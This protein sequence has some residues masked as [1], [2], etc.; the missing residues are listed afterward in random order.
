ML[1]EFLDL[2]SGLERQGACNETELPKWAAWKAWSACDGR[3]ADGDN[4]PKDR[5]H[6]HQSLRA[7][8]TLKILSH[9]SERMREDQFR[10]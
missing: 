10:R 9:C 6:F 5:S 1:G 7:L 2:G 3:C 8:F 4:V